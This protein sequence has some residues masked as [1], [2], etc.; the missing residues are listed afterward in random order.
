MDKL[1][2]PLLSMDRELASIG[3]GV[4]HIIDQIHT[5]V[6][7]CIILFALFSITKAIDRAVHGGTVNNKLRALLTDTTHWLCLYDV[8][9]RTLPNGSVEV[10]Y[11]D[12]FKLCKSRATFARFLLKRLRRQG[13]QTDLGEIEKQISALGQTPARPPKR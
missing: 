12:G 10:V 4:S 13:D 5:V 3:R 9:Y 7:Y 8:K 1:Y 6:G 2:A 11:P